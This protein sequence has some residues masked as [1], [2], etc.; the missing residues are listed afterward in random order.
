MLPS[1]NFS[2]TF[3]IVSTTNL[4]SFMKFKETFLEIWPNQVP[5]PRQNYKKNCGQVPPKDPPWKTV[6][7]WL[8]WKPS[9]ISKYRYVGTQ[10]HCQTLGTTKVVPPPHIAWTITQFSESQNFIH[11]KIFGNWQS[12]N[13][14][15]TKHVF[16]KKFCDSRN[17][18][19]RKVIWDGSVFAE[20]T[21]K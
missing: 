14:M 21:I 13:L 2:Q 1:W 19:T 9:L 10:K 4:Q 6:A 7:A 11:E 3:F 8:A 16:S 17:F 12:R 15:H 20:R 18:V 5:Y